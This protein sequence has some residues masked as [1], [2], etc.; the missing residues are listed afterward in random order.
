LKLKS[1]SYSQWVGVIILC[2]LLLAIALPLTGDEAYYIMWGK[3]PALSY[4]DHP[5]MIGWI[6]AI[7]AFVTGQNVLAIRV[8][9]IVM[10]TMS[11]ILLFH[12]LKAAGKESA[13]L[14]SLAYL[15][16]PFS[17]F[18]VL[19]CP[20]TAV[21]LAAM[22]AIY[23]MQLAIIQRSSLFACMAGIGLGL[24]ALSKFIAIIVVPGFVVMTFM[25]A[26][27]R[28]AFKLLL[29]AA[30]PALS[31][32][33]LCLWTSYT[34]C[35]S[36]VRFNFGRLD[37]DDPFNVKSLLLYG[38]SLAFLLYPILV[39]KLIR[40][41]GQGRRGVRR[42]WGSEKSGYQYIF[43]I[44]A[45]F[46][47]A[48]IGFIPVATRDV[49]GLHWFLAIYPFSFIFLMNEK[50]RYI[51]T[52]IAAGALVSL[53]LMA[54]LAYGLSQSNDRF[55]KWR[56]Y[57]DLIVA[58]HP[59]EV[60]KVLEDFVGV[61]QFVGSTREYSQSSILEIA[62]GRQFL[63]LEVGA[64]Y[65]RSFDAFHDFRT[66][67]GEL[68]AYISPDPIDLKRLPIILEN[69]RVGSREL[70]G[71]SFHM[72]A[73]RFSY[74]GYRDLILKTAQKRFYTKPL[75]FGLPKDQCFM[76]RRYQIQ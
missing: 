69:Y 35:W 31:G 33:Y 50:K 4:Y 67:E 37:F 10:T 14:V 73:G 2:R 42:L 74:S 63:T 29:I 39:A 30:V 76:Q 45:V 25:M 13:K 70:Y 52:A 68:V 23:F 11:G 75:P 21:L 5:P 6:H 3:Y 65:G 1:F 7:M 27:W 22:S 62:C 72:I 43:P 66:L 51:N 48:S 32:A 9:A 49:V 18:F 61:N 56:Y 71:Q 17:F 41:I 44:L 58:K 40:Y 24:A 46:V 38:A 12:I 8:L 57:P 36:N 20:D 16:S 55:S 15:V 26:P 59:L 34:N 64:K 28:R 19:S 47:A 60:C 54:L 53:V